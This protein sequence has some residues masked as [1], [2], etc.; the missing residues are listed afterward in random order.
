MKMATDPP[1][2][3]QAATAL[4]LLELTELTAIRTYSLHVEREERDEPLDARVA[5][6]VQSTSSHLEVRCKMTLATEE[7]SFIVDRS[8]VFTH[9]TP[10]DA[11]EA[12]TREFIERVGVMAVYPY[13][14]EAVFTLASQTGV[15]PPV[16]S[17]IR[18][19]SIGVNR[20]HTDGASADSST[21]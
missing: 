16:L 3:K 4:E 7:A 20:L 12:V 13:L 15:T 14:R 1:Q 19:G 5:I 17:L 2:P 11:D 10:V 6:A 8:A 21:E 18:G 9:T